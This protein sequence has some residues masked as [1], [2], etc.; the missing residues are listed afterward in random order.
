MQEEIGDITQR[1]DHPANLS[2]SSLVLVQA[3][4]RANK[5][6][7]DQFVLDCVNLCPDRFQ[8]RVIMIDDGVEKRV[9]QVVRS[10]LA[11]SAFAAA[12]ARAH[13]LKDIEVGFLLD[14]NEKG[15]PEEHAHLFGAYIFV[16]LEINH[17]GEE[18]E[19]VVILFDLWALV[20]IEHV[21]QGERVQVEALTQDAQDTEVAQA[22]DVN[23]GHELVIEM[24]EKLVTVYVRFFFKAVGPVL[25]QGDDRGLLWRILREL[26]HAGRFARDHATSSY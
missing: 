19:I 12:D 18:E 21:F 3:A 25:D 14:G 15:L 7:V 16:V 26:K 22:I 20:G 24:P 1:P 11:N 23:P 2:E 9:G 6:I 4:D 17:F 8:D 5:W 13:G 10:R